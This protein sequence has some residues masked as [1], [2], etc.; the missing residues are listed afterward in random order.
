MNIDSLI[1]NA[2]ERI[3]TNWDLPERGFIAGG[4]IANIVWEL[5][6]GNKAV[7][8]DVDI[9]HFDGEIEAIDTSDNS[10]LFRY[11]EKDTK[12]FE[13]YVGMC[14]TQVNKDFY[15]IV[16]SD[17]EGIFN[18][19]K[20]KSNK[21][22]TDLILR[23]FD[24]NSTGV[25]YSIEED[26]CYW[27][28]DFEKFLQSGEL[29]V[30]NLMT[31]SHTSI[32]LVKK[33]DEL[34]CKLDHF[35]IDLLKHSLEWRFSDIIKIRFRERYFNL[36]EKYKDVLSKDFETKRDEVAEE[37][38]KVQFGEDVQLH[39]LVPKIP[40]ELVEK[41]VDYVE[42][43][44]GRQVFSDDNIPKIYNSNDFLFYMRNIYKNSDLKLLWENVYY[45]YK[46]KEYVD[47]LPE[48]E[49]LEFLSRVAKYAPDSIENLKG[50]K[51]SEQIK[52]VKEVF[53]KF[54]ND[55]IVAISILERHK[56]NEIELTEDNLFLLELS[57]RK[58]IVNDT[59][60]KVN[61]VLN[62]KE[63]QKNPLSDPNFWL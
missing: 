36:F 29:K 42:F 28:E 22:D 58:K 11:Q 33:A 47:C 60:G 53:Q 2:I 30:C 44:Y 24:I 55:P 8:N 43:V 62:I 15:V 20:Y 18:N 63:E 9:F 1:R 31:P 26:K 21:P 54:E 41:S 19:I 3:K 13:D 40:K 61:K 38:V 48:K 34:N 27:T 23:S 59:K 52:L 35:E 49:D 5:V 39:Y 12:F 25:G 7:I 17:T 45:F 51:L 46:E 4:S 32:R 14:H 6:S 50:L 10:L 37:Y 57:V 56:L 16:S